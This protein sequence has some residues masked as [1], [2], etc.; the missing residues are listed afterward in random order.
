MYS[1]LIFCWDWIGRA[2]R[3][4]LIHFRENNAFEQAKHALQ[5][6]GVTEIYGVPYYECSDDKLLQLLDLLHG[7]L[8]EAD[9]TMLYR[10]PTFQQL[11]EQERKEATEAKKRHEE[12]IS[13]QEEKKKLL[14][15]RITELE[16][17]LN[18]FHANRE[19]KVS[20]YGGLKDTMKVEQESREHS[21]RALI[22]N[23]KRAKQVMEM[24]KQREIELEEKLKSKDLR[25]ETMVEN[26]RRSEESASCKVEQLQTEIEEMTKKLESQHQRMEQLEHQTQELRRKIRQKGEMQSS[27][28]KEI[29][30]R[31]TL[32]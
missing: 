10:N 12:E 13:E 29:A 3:C 4:G 7:C 26:L 9:V 17:E 2:P 11:C 28:Q 27:E 22:E 1:R 16:Q 18:E 30:A 15:R 24:Y 14:Q 32:I 21:E 6:L 8:C 5:N 23:E 31:G 20:E 19:S 25:I